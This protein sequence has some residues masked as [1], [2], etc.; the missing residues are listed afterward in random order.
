M[1]TIHRLILKLTFKLDLKLDTRLK[2]PPRNVEMLPRNN[3]DPKSSLCEQAVKGGLKKR[4]VKVTTQEQK[5]K[6]VNSCNGLLCLSDPTRNNPLVVCNPVTGEYLNLP[7]THEFIG[8][9]S[10]LVLADLDSVTRATRIKFLE[11]LKEIGNS[12]IA[13]L[14]VKKSSQERLLKY[15]QLEQVSGDILVMLHTVSMK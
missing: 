7:K 4:C 15:T 13:Q 14:Q 6:I 11:Y 1:E 12:V 10:G 9:S 8:S 5:F 3:A 2:I